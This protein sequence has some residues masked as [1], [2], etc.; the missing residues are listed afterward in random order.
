[1]STEAE[2]R[3]AAAEVFAAADA[4]PTPADGG[5]AKSPVARQ[6]EPEEFSPA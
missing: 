2:A 1:V 6:A 5:A 4:M 3:L